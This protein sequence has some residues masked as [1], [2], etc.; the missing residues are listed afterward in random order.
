[1]SS[2]SRHEKEMAR[3]DAK[4]NGLL[5]GIWENRR[6]YRKSV[7]DAGGRVFVSPGVDRG[8]VISFEI[9]GMDD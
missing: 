9:M 2:A 8:G 4:I 6:R 1:M 5:E 3:L 7:E